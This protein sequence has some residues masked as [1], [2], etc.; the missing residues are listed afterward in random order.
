MAKD[1]ILDDSLADAKFEVYREFYSERDAAPLIDAL[2]NSNIPYEVEVPPLI[3]DTV[4]GGDPHTPR[5]F[6]KVRRQ[7]FTQIEQLTEAHMLAHLEKSA[8][9]L[10]DHFLYNFSNDELLDVLRKPDS[11]SVDAV[12]IARHLLQQR[13]VQISP[14]EIQHMRTEHQQTLRQ[15]QAGSRQWIIALYL[16]AVLNA[17]FLLPI[18]IAYLGVL[19]TCIGMGYYYWRG[20]ALDSNGERYLLFDAATQQHGRQIVYLTIAAHLLGWFLLSRLA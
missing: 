12:V 20:T 6:V 15:P 11:W 1:T 18:L 16:L 4:M 8:P 14:E 13:G 7:D 3:M 17:A 2:K 5:I 19:C 10:E 9:P